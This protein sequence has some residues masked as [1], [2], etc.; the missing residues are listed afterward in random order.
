M[1]SE[2]ATVS[3]EQVFKMSEMLEAIMFPCPLLS[4][5][6]KPLSE[7]ISLETHPWRPREI[8]EWEILGGRAKILYSQRDNEYLR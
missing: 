7:V 1:R 2:Q 4:L 8:M 6:K 3:L 5:L